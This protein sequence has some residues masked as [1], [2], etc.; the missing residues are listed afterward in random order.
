M[1]KSAN[2]LSVLMVSMLKALKQISKN[3]ITMFLGH[4]SF[5]LYHLKAIDCFLHLSMQIFNKFV[6]ALGDGK[7]NSSTQAKDM[8]H[9]IPAS[10]P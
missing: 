8:I 7:I 5:F 9:F 1:A 10:P 2:E 3:I 6:K 4:N